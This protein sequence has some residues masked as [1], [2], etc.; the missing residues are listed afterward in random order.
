M[1]VLFGGSF[2]PV[3][4]AHLIVARDVLEDFGFSEVIFVPAN[5]QP[6]KGELYIPAHIRLKALKAAVEGEKGFSVWD[7]EIRRG[8][9]SYTYQTLKVFR[10]L[11]K[12]EPV[13]MMGADSFLTFHLWKKPREILRLSRILVVSRPGCNFNPGEVLARLGVN[14]KVARFKRGSAEREGW[15]VAVYDGRL[16][17]ISSTE[18][19]KRLKSGR[20]IS[21]LVPNGVEEV[22]REWLTGRCSTK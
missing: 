17:E 2:N 22:I 5:V 6:L 14:L 16:L 8:G 7:C 20:P 11:Y 13:F 10:E 19:R 1:K 4:V 3:H 15:R 9:T 21:Y 18:I 12:E